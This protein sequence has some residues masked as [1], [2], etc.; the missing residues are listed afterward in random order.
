MVA[1]DDTTFTPR[2]KRC[3]KA[4]RQRQKARDKIRKKS[5]ALVKAG[6]IERTPCVCAFREFLPH[7]SG[8]YC[9]LGGRGQQA[10][11]SAFGGSFL[12]HR[13]TVTAR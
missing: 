11:R 9:H 6:V 10:N 12:R 8:N 2:K 5:R 1:R 3:E 7:S 13:R 4:W